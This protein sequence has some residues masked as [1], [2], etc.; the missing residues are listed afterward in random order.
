[1]VTVIG[2]VDLGGHAQA[3]Q[4]GLGHAAVLANPSLAQRTPFLM[5]GVLVF[6]MSMWLIYTY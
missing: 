2:L 5:V 6:H 3:P 1:M 4:D